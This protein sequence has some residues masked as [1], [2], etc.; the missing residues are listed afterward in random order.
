MGWNF[1]EAVTYYQKQGAP[2]EQS[3]VVSLL[4]EIQSENGGSIPQYMLERVAQVYEIRASYLLAIVRR[5]PS[6]RMSDRHLL[7][8]CAGPNCGKHL[9]IADCAEQLCKAS[10]GKV[11]LKFAPCMRMCGKGPNVRLDGTVHNGMTEEKLRKLF[12]ELGYQN[13]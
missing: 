5:I 10:A 11:Q 13:G 6:L 7:E 2:R 4:R 8:V 9:H 12:E 1:E 3:A